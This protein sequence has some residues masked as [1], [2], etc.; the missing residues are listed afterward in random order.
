MNYN[1]LFNK[2]TV[3][4]TLFLTNRVLTHMC[5]FLKT[6]KTGSTGWSKRLI[7]TGKNR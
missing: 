6:V 5:I 4:D 2:I 7:W 1:W 3:A